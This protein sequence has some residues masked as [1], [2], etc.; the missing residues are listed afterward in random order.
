MEI[1]T[2][3]L[4]ELLDSPSENPVLYV[5]R[6]EESGGPVR[7]SVWDE[8]LVHHGD[9]VLRRH[10]LTDVVGLGEVGEMDDLLPD[11]QEMVDEILKG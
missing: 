10:E 7:L 6:D 3:D 1:R 8:A 2:G 4:R 5:E 9:V 11:F